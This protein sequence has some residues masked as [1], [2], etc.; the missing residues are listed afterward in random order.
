MVL[1]SKIPELVLPLLVFLSLFPDKFDGGVTWKHLIPLVL[2]WLSFIPYF[3][4][5]KHRKILF[6]KS[7]LF[8]FGTLVIQ[9]LV[10]STVLMSFTNIEEILVFTIAFLFWRCILSLP[11]SLKKIND[12]KLNLSAITWPVIVIIA[13]RGFVGLLAQFTLNLALIDGH[14]LLIWPLLNTSVIL[15]AVASQYFLK[16][17]IHSSDWV[18]LSGLFLSSCLL[19]I[20]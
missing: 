10:G 20:I 7:A 17:R 16:E 5:G 4:G 13:V 14:P 8:L 15:S 18:A 12:E 1:H 19:Q 3:M 6:D 2:T 9:M 11:L